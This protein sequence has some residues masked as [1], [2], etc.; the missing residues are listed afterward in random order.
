M[1]SKSDNWKRRWAMI[2]FVTGASVGGM[3]GLFFITP[4]LAKEISSSVA[5]ISAALIG[6]VSIYIGGAVWD[7]KK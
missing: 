2:R 4:E 5:L 3:V 1:S 7:D 6:L